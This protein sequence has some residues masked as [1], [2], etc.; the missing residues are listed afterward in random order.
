MRPVSELRLLGKIRWR[1][2]IVSGCVSE[3]KR[4]G[5]SIGA[6]ILSQGQDLSSNRLPYAHA[7]RFVRA[8]GNG[9]ERLLQLGV[10]RRLELRIERYEDVV[11]RGSGSRLLGSRGRNTAKRNQ[12]RLMCTIDGIDSVVDCGVHHGKTAGRGNRGWRR[13][14]GPHG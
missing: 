14:R 2:L 4:N 11:S 10:E 6:V 5:L 9:C 12:I 3:N 13:A 8:V 7:L 1:R